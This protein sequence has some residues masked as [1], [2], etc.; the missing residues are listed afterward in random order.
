MAL[1][2]QQH[3]G[4]FIIQTTGKFP[5]TQ[6]LCWLIYGEKKLFTVVRPLMWSR[7]VYQILKLNCIWKKG[8]SVTVSTQTEVLCT[9][10]IFS[11]PK[12]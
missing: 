3:A 2:G 5:Y 9:A 1:Q 12:L 4:V 8:K 6:C 11:L 7:T 10:L